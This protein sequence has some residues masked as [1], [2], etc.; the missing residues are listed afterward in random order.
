MD[1]LEKILKFV[2]KEGENYKN[3]INETVVQE[4]QKMIVKFQKLTNK[5]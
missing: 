2:F 5:M 1:E 3:E 4:S